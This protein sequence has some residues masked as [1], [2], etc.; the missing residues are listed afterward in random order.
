MSGRLERVLVGEWVVVVLFVRVLLDR[1]DGRSRGLG[2]SGGDWRRGP[3]HRGRAWRGGGTRGWRV[4]DAQARDVRRRWGHGV[5]GLFGHHYLM[6]A[7]GS[8]LVCWNYRTSIDVSLLGQIVVRVTVGVDGS[9]ELLKSHE[10]R[11]E[12]VVG[13]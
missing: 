10:G 3:R 4:A 12:L 13:S 2:R 11:D 9:V 5:L 1:L 8:G 6:S 7:F